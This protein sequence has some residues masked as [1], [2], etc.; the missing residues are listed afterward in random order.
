MLLAIVL[1]GLS[2]CDVTLR[3][4]KSDQQGVSWGR[5]LLDNPIVSCA[6]DA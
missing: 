6:L 3:A 1:T 2:F 5:I 4:G